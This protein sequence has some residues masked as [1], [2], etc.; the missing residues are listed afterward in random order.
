MENHT[1][2]GSVDAILMA[3]GFSHRFGHQNKLLQPFCGKPLAQHALQLAAGF[4]G[5]AHVWFVYAAGSVGRL[6]R[7]APNVTPIQNQNPKRG[8]C[9]SVRLGVLSSSAQHYLFMQ[10]DQPLLDE[11]TLRALL[12]QRAPGRIVVPSH[13]GQNGSPVLFSAAFR[14]QLLA[15]QSGQNAR[16][17]L[18]ANPGAIV[19]VEIANPLPLADID[20][21]EDLARLEALAGALT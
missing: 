12:A 14:P 18:Q 7:P 8:S 6:A 3:S 4:S 10:C 15:L 2:G 21:P 11:A 5:F 13:G 17:I 1:P 20:T 16:S 9:E 19:T